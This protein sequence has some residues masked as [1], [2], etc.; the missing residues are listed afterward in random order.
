MLSLTLPITLSLTVSHTLSLTLLIQL[1]LTLPITKSLTLLPKLLLKITH[2]VTMLSLTWPI[3]LSLTFS[4]TLPLTLLLTLSPTQPLSFSL[5][6]FPLQSFWSHEVW[7]TSW[8]NKS[9][10]IPSPPQCRCPD[11]RLQGKESQ[12]N[13]C[14]SIISSTHCPSPCMSL[15]N[16]ISSTSQRNPAP[17]W[18]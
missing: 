4:H 1:S 12:V 7:Q 8:Q 9:G 5:S 2:T 3:T 10:H 17:R 11:L 6:I 16:L 13:I 18:K 15:I 14:L